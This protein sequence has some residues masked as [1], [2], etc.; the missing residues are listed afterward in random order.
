V[1]FYAKYN[2]R[3][4][5]QVPDALCSECVTM[6]NAAELEKT[7]IEEDFIRIKDLS[8]PNAL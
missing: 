6:L 7:Q 8:K 1:E 3:P 4:R 5:L 2:G